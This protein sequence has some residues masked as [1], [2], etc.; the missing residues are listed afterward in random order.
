MA[1]SESDSKNNLSNDGMVDDSYD[2]VLDGMHNDS[3]DLCEFDNVGH[4]TT[5]RNSISAKIAPDLLNAPAADVPADY[6]IQLAMNSKPEPSNTL[7]T[8][9][10]MIDDSLRMYLNAPPLVRRTVGTKTPCLS[11]DPTID[12]SQ[13]NALSTSELYVGNIPSKA[14]WYELKKWFI[15]HGHG[16]S[17][18]VLKT[19]PVRISS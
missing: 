2:N 12:E 6:S 1:T 9:P 11:I 16:V 7:Y 5:L 17:R 8:P 14:K 19:N 4:F 15:D 3:D 18:V 10:P 13:S